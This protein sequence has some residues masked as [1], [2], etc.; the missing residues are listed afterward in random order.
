MVTPMSFLRSDLDSATLMYPECFMH[1][2]NCE[3][4]LFVSNF[5]GQRQAQGSFFNSDFERSF[6]VYKGTLFSQRRSFFPK[7]CLGLPYGAHTIFE[8]LQPNRGSNAD[9]TKKVLEPMFYSHLD[10][11][12][13]PN[14]MRIGPLI[15]KLVFW[16]A[17]TIFEGSRPKRGSNIDFTKKCSGAK[18]F[19]QSRHRK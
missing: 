18:F 13:E 6:R 3:K 15:R 11:E 14:I 17:L 16:G 10:K 12:N 5:G 1:I 9:F 19:V 8:G 4:S 2:I 7:F